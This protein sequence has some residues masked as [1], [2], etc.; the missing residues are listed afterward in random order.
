[1]GSCRCFIP[2]IFFALIVILFA[3]GI[4]I[5]NIVYF[6]KI[7]SGGTLSKSTT[8]SMIWISGIALAATIALGIW[9]IYLIVKCSTK[10]YDC[11]HGFDVPEKLPELPN[12]PKLPWQSE[13]A[14]LQPAR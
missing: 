2:F 1:M 6:A 13:F 10:R 11:S 9:A 4:L 3:F 14:E 5:A 12:L 7:G 8:S